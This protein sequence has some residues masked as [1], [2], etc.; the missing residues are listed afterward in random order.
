MLNFAST[1]CVPVAAGPN[2]CETIRVSIHASTV[3]WERDGAPFTDNKYSRAHTW[4]FDGGVS[5]RASSSP[6]VVRPPLSAEDAVD[7][8]EA[9]VAALS[10]CHMLW[11]LALAAK[12][13]FVVDS[14]RDEAAG[15]LER[16]PDGRVWLTHVV[17][18]PHVRFSGANAPDAAQFERLH[19]DSHEQCNVTNSVKSEVRCEAVMERA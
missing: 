7:P 3:T 1:P 15:T 13:G 2:P 5:V 19:H 16:G 8:E 14:Y 6:A 17:L 4:S 9:L 18:R 10:S 12:G 11:F